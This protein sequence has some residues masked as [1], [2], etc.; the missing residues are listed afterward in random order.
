MAIKIPEKMQFEIS[1]YTPL[2]IPMARL[3]EYMA[4][5]ATMLGYESSVHFDGLEAG[6][7]LVNISIAQEDQLKVYEQ[8]LAVNAGTGPKKAMDAYDAINQLLAQDN[9]DGRVRDPTG[10]EIIYF[11]GGLQETPQAFGPVTESGEL[12]GI[13]VAI[14]GR[15]KDEF[16]P[17]TLESAGR[18]FNCSANR[19]MAREIAA[20]I[21]QNEIR[22]DGKGSWERAA[23]GAWKLKWFR[24]QGFQVLE[25]RPMDEVLHDLRAI[26]GSDWKTMTNP[27]AELLRLRHSD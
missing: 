17:I 26:P 25:D 27:V 19:T 7:T 8:V 21:F 13:P 1:A 6:S 15:G 14:G 23:D 5:Y 11:P 2:T 24:I 12:D 9:A 10:A 20:H 4:Q 22:V 16:V 3:A 18:F